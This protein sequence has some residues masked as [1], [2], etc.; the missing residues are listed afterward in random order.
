MS[1]TFVSLLNYKGTQSFFI[2]SLEPHRKPM[3]FTIQ[4]EPYRKFVVFNNH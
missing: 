3:V 2:A 4:F 1:N